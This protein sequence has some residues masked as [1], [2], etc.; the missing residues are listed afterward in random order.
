MLVS[1]A[2]WIFFAPPGHGHFGTRHPNKRGRGLYTTVRAPCPFQHP[3]QRGLYDA[4]RAPRAFR[5]P[6]RIQSGLYSM[7]MARCQPHSHSGT[8]P[9]FISAVYWFIA[10]E[11]H[12]HFGTR[13][14]DIRCVTFRGGGESESAAR[15]L[16]TEF[17][18]VIAMG[19]SWGVSLC[20]VCCS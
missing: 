7:R 4:F 14:L 2:S 11:P 19:A 10:F 1:A 3:N 8:R 12:D 17:E 6:N 20:G 18:A 16:A 9:G 5:H 13:K 15:K